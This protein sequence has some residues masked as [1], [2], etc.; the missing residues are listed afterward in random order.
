MPADS[1]YSVFADVNGSGKID[2]LDLVVV[3]QN[4]M[5]MLPGG[6]P[7]AAAAPALSPAMALARV[8]VPG[9]LFGIVPVRAASRENPVWA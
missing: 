9:G 2:G 7:A 1:I 5:V 6:E 3:R 8:V 4:Q